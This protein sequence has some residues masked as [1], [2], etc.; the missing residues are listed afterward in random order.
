MI[1]CGQCKSAKQHCFIQYLTSVCS[2]ASTTGCPCN[3]EVAIGSYCFGE[4]CCVICSEL[5]VKLLAFEG[6][7]RFILAFPL[8]EFACFVTIVEAYFT[9][10]TF[11]L[12]SQALIYPVN[13]KSVTRC[14]AYV[15]AVV[16]SFNQTKTSGLVTQLK[17]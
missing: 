6:E 16:T 13:Q 9:S 3:C 15:K 11:P 14:P 2:L 1:Q 12:D 10:H 7:H 8:L 4:N 17:W 5:N